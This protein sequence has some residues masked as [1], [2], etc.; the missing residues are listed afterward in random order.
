MI[1]LKQIKNY[2]D[3]LTTSPASRDRYLDEVLEFLKRSKTYRKS[4][5]TFASDS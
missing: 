3:S 1:L 2:Y 4:T 5:E